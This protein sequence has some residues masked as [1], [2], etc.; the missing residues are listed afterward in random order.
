MNQNSE[1][2]SKNR[3]VIAES[4]TGEK[5]WPTTWLWAN[6]N[7]NKGQGVETSP[8]SCVTPGKLP[9]FSGPWF[10]P[11]IKRW[12]QDLSF[13]GP[14]TK[15]P[16]LCSYFLR[17]QDT[18][19]TKNVSPQQHTAR[20]LLPGSWCLWNIKQH[21]NPRAA[22]LHDA[23]AF[24]LYSV[25]MALLSAREGHPHR[26]QLRRRRFRD[27]VLHS[28]AVWWD[29]GWTKAV[30]RFPPSHPRPSS[31]GER[32]AGFRKWQ[33]KSE[34]R[35]TLLP[36]QRRFFLGCASSQLLDTRPLAEARR[37]L[38]LWTWILGCSLHV[39]CPLPDHAPNPGPLHQ[40]PGGVLPTG[41]PLS[42]RN[43]YHCWTGSHLTLKSLFIGT[44]L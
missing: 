22:A 28:M 8:N 36:Q 21:L 25:K 7:S 29:G 11:P 19:T 9:P 31:L 26:T 20:Q 43:F 5:Y 14:S 30:N 1:I 27:T 40:E 24:R 2:N 18:S 17:W 10:L 41:P 23:A 6:N 16:W 37:I 3:P 13:S 35:R 12:G 38:Q 32:W 34:P 4:P 33:S 15:I 44:K 39:G 42:P